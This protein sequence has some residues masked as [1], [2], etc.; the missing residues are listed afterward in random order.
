MSSYVTVCEAYYKKDET[1]TGCHSL[2]PIVKPIH[3]GEYS[4]SH[5]LPPEIS[6]SYVPGLVEVGCYYYCPAAEGGQQ[7]DVSQEVCDLFY[8]RWR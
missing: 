7:M 6:P 8:L 3:P 4:N 5:Q 1:L 2:D